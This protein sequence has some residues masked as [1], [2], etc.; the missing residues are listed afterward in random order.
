M[1]MLRDMIASDI[2]DH[3]DWFARPN[4]E[5]DWNRYDAVTFIIDLQGGWL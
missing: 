5:N 2:E 3:V 1:V 4:D